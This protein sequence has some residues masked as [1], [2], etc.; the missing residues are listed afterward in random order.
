MSTDTSPKGAPEIPEQSWTNPFSEGTFLNEIY[1][2]AVREERD[3]AIVVDDYYARRGTGKTVSTLK[4]ADGMDRTDQTITEDKSTLHPEGLRQAYTR[5]PLGSSLVLDEAEV[6]V[7]N[8]Q[9]MSKVNQAMREIM[10]MGRVEQ[11]YVVINAPLKSFIDK[12]ILK[13][14]DAWISMVRKGLGLVHHLKWEPY[15][16][17]LLTPRKQ[18]IEFDDIERGTELRATYNYLT[19]EKKDAMQGGTGNSFIAE[20]EHQK[21]LKKRVKNAKREKR[22]KIIAGVYKHPQIDASQAKIADAVGVSQKTV[23]NALSRVEDNS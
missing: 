3:V 7:S 9:A 20:D 6:G 2:D 10:S 15:S 12:D 22:D 18:W 21:E 8:R 17:Q 13:M 1:G 16:E 14:C 19:A 23:S 11:K 5:E 4:L